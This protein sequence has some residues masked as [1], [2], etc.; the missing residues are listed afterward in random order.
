MAFPSD[1]AVFDT[2]LGVPSNRDAWQKD[3]G[4]LVRDK[5]SS[6]LKHPGGYMFKD[7]PEV[8][9]SV[10]YPEFLVAEMDKYNIEFGLV[11]VSFAEG[12][13][14]RASVLAHPKRLFGSMLVDPNRGMDAIRYNASADRQSWAALAGLFHEVF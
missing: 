8:D 10:S 11:P 5:A 4:N 2:M 7:L 12:D 3:F 1:V 9:A 14:G 13:I 6:D